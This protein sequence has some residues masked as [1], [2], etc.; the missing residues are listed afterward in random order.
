MTVILATWK[1]LVSEF[2]KEM[3]AR[4]LCP[5]T[6]GNIKKKTNDFKLKILS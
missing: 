2:K 4:L 1:S 5:I 3:Q 6:Y